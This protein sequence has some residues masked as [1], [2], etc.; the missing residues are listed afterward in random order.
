[1]YP[2]FPYSR[3]IALVSFICVISV[4]FIGGCS[5]GNDSGDGMR[6]EDPFPNPFTGRFL[7]NLEDLQI[8]EGPIDPNLNDFDPQVLQT[9][10]DD[11]GRQ[12]LCKAVYELITDDEGTDNYHG[13]F[14]NNST[15]LSVITIS[16]FILETVPAKQLTFRSEQANGLEV[17][18]ISDFYYLS[19]SITS[20]GITTV[21]VLDCKTVTTRFSEN[22]VQMR[23]ILNSV[24]LLRVSD[25]SVAQDFSTILWFDYLG[26]EEEA[27]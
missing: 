18:G 24:D 16:D 15:S 1:M 3:A 25:D 13:Q 21:L 2:R 14:L 9:A 10:Q 22:E 6:K 4:F 5:S 20:Y 8:I 17:T 7:W 19:E 11:D 27:R 23:R 12:I 26:L